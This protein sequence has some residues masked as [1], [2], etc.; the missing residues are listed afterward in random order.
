MRTSGLILRMTGFS[1]RNN[2]IESL[3]IYKILIVNYNA[4]VCVNRLYAVSSEC[5]GTRMDISSLDLVSTCLFYSHSSAMANS[6]FGY[7]LYSKKTF[8][9]GAIRDELKLRYWLGAR[10]AGYSHNVLSQG[11]KPASV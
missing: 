11:S 1:G 9:C 2:K 6:Q 10:L 8:P 5:V 4:D 3:A 7:H